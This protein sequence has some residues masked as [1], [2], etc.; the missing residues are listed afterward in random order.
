MYSLGLD[1]K[2][3]YFIV[4]IRQFI[5]FSC[6][7]RMVILEPIVIW[8]LCE[9]ENRRDFFEIINYFPQKKIIFHI[10]SV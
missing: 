7:C 5:R 6:V 4:E 3:I 10:F 1:L 9:I 2:P 8:P